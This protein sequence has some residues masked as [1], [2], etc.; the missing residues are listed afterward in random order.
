MVKV[1]TAFSGLT[2]VEIAWRVYH[3]PEAVDSDV[4]TFDRAMVLRYY[5]VPF[6]A[7]AQIVLIL[8]R[9]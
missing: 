7:M 1:E 2:T 4:R 8:S 6:S 5:R 3:A 9:I